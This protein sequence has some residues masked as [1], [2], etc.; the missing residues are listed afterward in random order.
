MAYRRPHLAPPVRSAGGPTAMPAVQPRRPCAAAT[1]ADP[2]A[3]AAVAHRP[4]GLVKQTP[5][6]VSFLIVRASGTITVPFGINWHQPDR[7]HPL[8]AGAYPG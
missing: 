5:F 2:S 8:D 6:N 4:P 7:V 3:V 1:S